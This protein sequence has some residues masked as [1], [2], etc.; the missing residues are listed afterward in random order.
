MRQ[1]LNEMN[2]IPGVMGGYVY[3]PELGV[4]EKNLPPVFKEE[5]LRDISTQLVA[6]ERHFGSDFPDHTDAFLFFEMFA[7]T[8]RE[9]E[10]NFF[11]ILLFDPKSK[12]NVLSVSINLILEEMRP[13]VREYKADEVL[14]SPSKHH[15]K[16]S[17][18]SS[19]K[20]NMVEEVMSKGPLSDNLKELEKLLVKIL[21]P[22]APLMFKNALEQWCE[23]QT[24]S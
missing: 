3:N 16:N 4:I 22:V 5:R 20:R 15:P 6:L 9:I 12:T 18:K 13:L 2:L 24:P 11:F 10:N 19:V 23:E 17:R 7:I 8:I 14:E 1:A 21:G